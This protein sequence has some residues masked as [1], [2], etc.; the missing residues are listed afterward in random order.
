[1]C[2]ARPQDIH[3]RHTRMG[4]QANTATQAIARADGK[5]PEV[6]G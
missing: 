2:L 3:G 4:H 5:L 6:T 1:M